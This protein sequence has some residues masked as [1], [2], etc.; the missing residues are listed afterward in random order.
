MLA[1]K[2]IDG[3][4]K[5]PIG[6]AQTEPEQMY[7]TVKEE[8]KKHLAGLCKIDSGELVRNRIEKFCAMGVYEEI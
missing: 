4:I 8:I 3:I 7:Q 5:E 1:N 2:L 6:G